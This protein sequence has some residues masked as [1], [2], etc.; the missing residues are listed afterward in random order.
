M[1]ADPLVENQLWEQRLQVAEPPAQASLL[2]LQAELLNRDELGNL[3]VADPLIPGVLN[4]LTYTLLTGR[5]ATYKTML[6]L[7]WCLSLATGTA[8]HRRP[9][10]KT[11]VLYLIGEGAYD[12]DARISAWE[13]SS[14]VDVPADQFVT[15]PRVPNLFKAPELDALLELIR[16]GGFGLVVVDTLRRAS[17]GADMNGSDMAR[18]VDSLEAIKRA[19]GDGAVLVLAHT[20]KGDNDS[21]GFS[22]IEDDADIVWHC[23]RAPGAATVSVTNKKMRNGPDGA[24]L[25]LTPRQAESSIVLDLLAE[26]GHDHRPA[27]Q[28]VSPTALKVLNVLRLPGYEDGATAADLAT[29]AG[30]SR[31]RISDATS[32]LIQSGQ[33]TRTG[34]RGQFAYTAVRMETGQ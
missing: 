30:L 21:R 20:D 1:T 32:E 27:D 13:Q 9:V 4:R 5:D 28:R 2:A 31:Q 22:G 29:T 6:T 3:P 26:S 25:T 17:T 8:W 14:G 10:D 34:A 16:Q 24:T 15:L 11:R 12:F 23:K 19:T 18:V 33:V 7:S